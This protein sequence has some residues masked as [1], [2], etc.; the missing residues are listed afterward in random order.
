MLARSAAATLNHLLVQS[1]WAMSRL[2]RF[3]GKTA[4]FDITPFSVSFTIQDDGTLRA[5]ARD[6]S[7]DAHCVIA[8]TLLPRLALHDEKAHAEIISTGDP[9]LLSEELRLSEVL[10][11]FFTDL[12]PHDLPKAVEIGL[13]AGHGG[14]RYRSLTSPRAKMLATK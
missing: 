10:L 11:Q 2:A 9:A 6:D 7:P 3:A 12:P 14:L 4:R 1:G 13:D 5:A 8:P